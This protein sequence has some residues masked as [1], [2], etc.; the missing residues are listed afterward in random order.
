MNVASLLPPS[1]PLSIHVWNFK[2]LS[3]QNSLLG[4]YRAN[5]PTSPLLLTVELLPLIANI[6]LDGNLSQ[7]FWAVILLK[8]PLV[9]INRGLLG[10]LQCLLSLSLSFQNL[11]FPSF[12]A[13]LHRGIQQHPK[14]HALKLEQSPFDPPLWNIFLAA[15]PWEILL[16]KYSEFLLLLMENRDQNNPIFRTVVWLSREDVYGNF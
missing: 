9:Q 14:A 2:L 16:T 12:R 7:S 5:P 6:I 15:M 3:L 1:S 13:S 11:S 4:K 8:N 10:C